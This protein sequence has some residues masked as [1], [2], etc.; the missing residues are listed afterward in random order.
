[1]ERLMTLFSYASQTDIWAAVV[2]LLTAGAEHVFSLVVFRCPCSPDLN[3]VYGLSFL[4][5]PALALL[6]L[7]YILNKKTWILLTGTCRIWSCDWVTANMTALLY[8][9]NF[10]LVAPS[11]WIAVALLSGNYFECAMAGTNVSSSYG[12]HLCEDT[13]DVEQCQRE[14]FRFPCGKGSGVSEADRNQVMLILKAHSQILGWL[15]IAS[16][17]LFN[18]LLICLGR[19]TSPI[20]YLQL[21]FWRTYTKEEN[22]L[23]NSRIV[24]HARKLAGRNLNSFFTDTPLKPFRSPLLICGRRSALCSSSTPESSSTVLCTATWRSSGK[25][26]E[27]I[28]GW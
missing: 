16:I 1:M 20:S 10:A 14:L 15:L 3:F 8:I 2:A 5:V 27:W 24:E 13:S 4:L 22:S 9:S 28:W 21:K 23:L 25:I 19:C 26:R 7:G 6:L 17:M 18:L 12:S 11:S